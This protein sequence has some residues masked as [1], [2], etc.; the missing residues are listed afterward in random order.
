VKYQTDV[1]SKMKYISPSQ[2]VELPHKSRTCLGSPPRKATT[3]EASCNTPRLPVKWPSLG[4]NNSIRDKKFRGKRMSTA[5]WNT[6]LSCILT[7]MHNFI[8]KLNKFSISDHNT[9][10]GTPWFEDHKPGPHAKLERYDYKGA[11]VDM[12][13]RPITD[14]NSTMKY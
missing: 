1:N 7:K 3:S 6:I 12:R 8:P 9:P 5:R 10:S 14:V 4:L 11:K 13:I 2:N